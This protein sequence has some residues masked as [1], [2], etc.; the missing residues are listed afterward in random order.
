MKPCV[1]SIAGFD[2][3]GGAGVLADCKTF[4]QMGATGLAALTAITYQSETLIQGVRWCTLSEIRSQLLPLFDC[5]EIR[6]V[7]IGIVKSVAMLEAIV[8]FVCD[9]GAGI[10]VIWDPVMQATTGYDFLA[11]K[12]TEIPFSNLALIT[13]NCTELCRLG[14]SAC[15]TTALETLAVRCPVYAKNFLASKDTI[16]NIF[17]RD[18]YKRSFTI[19]K[20]ENSDK[21][22]S[23]CVLSAAIAAGLALGNDLEYAIADA[24]VYIEN[25]LKSASGLLGYHT[26][27]SY[28]AVA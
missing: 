3:C 2:P 14:N 20:L 13:P 19:S 27:G 16:I 11:G 15:P 23:G 28:S 12:L 6:A 25:F 18:S 24:E 22:G 4:E 10:P 8:A 17:Q 7:K 9:R 26:G 21:H 5:Y 1:L